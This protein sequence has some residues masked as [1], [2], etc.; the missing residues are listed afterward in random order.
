MKKLFFIF[1][2]VMAIVLFS[3]KQ[4]QDVFPSLESVASFSDYDSIGVGAIASNSKSVSIRNVVIGHKKTGGVEEVL[5]LDKSGNDVNDELSVVNYRKSGSYLFLT[6]SHFRCGTKAFC[7]YLPTGDIFDLNTT[8]ISEDPPRDMVVV[9]NDAVYDVYGGVRKTYYENGLLIIEQLAAPEVSGFQYIMVDKYGNVFSTDWEKGHLLTSKGKLRNLPSTMKY[10]MG[11]NQIVYYEDGEAKG[12]FDE[13]GN[14]R[15]I[16]GSFYPSFIGMDYYSSNSRFCDIIEYVDENK[17]YYF[18]YEKG[19][20]NC[21][22]G[23]LVE[24]EFL[25]DEEYKEVV[26]SDGNELKSNSYGERIITRGYHL[27]EN[28]LYVLFSNRFIKMDM[29]TGVVS[30]VNDEFFDYKKLEYISD[31]VFRITVI[32]EDMNK[33]E[34]LI[35]AEGSKVEMTVSPLKIESI[36]LFPC[37]K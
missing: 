13:D 26:I 24:I 7:I 5:F 29:T 10:R 25:S 4:E 3:C 33:K 8:Y 21:F 15:K 17:H 34:I 27:Y 12:F 32:D 18:A 6:L 11:M 14:Q 1:L 23:D 2:L 30:I 22:R 37:N 20:F 16:S 35:D 31:D 19:G 36:V 9:K 28:Y